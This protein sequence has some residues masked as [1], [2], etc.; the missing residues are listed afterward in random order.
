[1]TAQSEHNDIFAGV[2]VVEIGQYIAAPAAARMMSDMGAEVFKVEMPPYGDMVRVYTVPHAPPGTLFIAENRGKKSVCIDLKRPEG[3]A[4][5]RDLIAHSDV[6]VE[7]YTPGVLSKYGIKYETLSSL[8]PRLIMCSISGFGQTGPLAHKPGND[9]IGQA[10]SGFLNLVGYP[11]RPPA[12]PGANLADNGAG[13]HALA[14]I[15]SA[16]YFREKTG[17]GQYIDLSLVECLGHYNSGNIVIHGLSDGRAKATRS[18]SHSPATAPFGIFKARDGYVALSVLINQW[19]TFCELI[20]K[21]EFSSDPRYDSIE[22]RVQHKDEVIKIVEDWLQ[23]F[24]SRDEPVALLDQVHIMGA[25]VLDTAGYVSDPQIR[26][27]EAIQAVAHPGVGVIGIPRAPFHFSGARVE[28]R[29]RAPM[30]GE[31]N[32]AALAAVAGYTK[33]TIAALEQA[34]VLHH[35]PQLDQMRASGELV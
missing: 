8:N 23:S 14:A 28:I 5:A 4:V 34:G 12:Y 20:G 3:A 18:G 26:A 11:D 27:R 16:L 17:R 13:I 21:P 25:P 6:L 31:H 24:E 2:R 35:D 32:E 29:S 7:N 15:A 33:E 30:L 22:H 1:V 10:M 9:L 19:E